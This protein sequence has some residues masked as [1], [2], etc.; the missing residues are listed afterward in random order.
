MGR[1]RTHRFAALPALLA[2]A[3]LA[4]LPVAAAAQVVINEI[5]PDPAGTDDPLERVE[6]YNAG[7]TAVDVTGW[8]IHDAASIDGSPALRCRIPEDF[9][10]AACPGGAIMQPGEFRVVKATTVMAWLNQGGDDVYLCSNRTIPATIVHQVTYPS[11]AGHV[12]EV[13]AAVPNGTSNFAWRTLSLCATNGGGGDVVAPA[14]VAN[15]AAT[16]GSFPGEIRL[17]WTAPGDDGAT[18]TAS[19]YIIKVAHFAIT[20]GTFD[21]VGD[22]DRWTLEPLPAAGGTAETLFVFGLDPDS[23]WFFALETQDEVPN[24]ST[25]SNSP[26]SAPLPGARLNPDL[27]YNAYFGNLHSHTGYSDGVQTPPIAYN[28]ARNI[29][30]TPLDFLAVTDHNHTTAGMSLPDYHTGLSEGASANS[31]GNFVAIYGQ[32]WGLATNGHVNVYE[33]PVLFG[34]DAGNF[35]TF[36]AEGDYAGLYSAAI[37]NPP[38]SYPV[39]IEWAHPA[40]GDFDNFQVTNDGRAAVH[41]MA[42]VNGPATSTAT[43]ESDIGNTGFDGAFHE[44]LRAGYRVSPTAD[45][46]NHNATWGASTE[47][48]TGV[49][50]LSKTKSA[51]LTAMAARR[52][53]ATQD[54]NAVVHFSADGHA[55]GEA[56]TATQG[57][58]I[59][60]EVIDTDPGETVSKIDLFRGITGTSIATRVGGNSGSSKFQWRELAPPAPGTEYHYYVEARMADNQNIWTGPVYVTYQ[61]SPVAIVEPPPDWGLGLTARPN[62]TRAGV[63]AD[64]ILP[65][66][67]SHVSLA[68]YDLSGRLRRTLMSG[69]LYAGPHRVIWDGR[70]ESG[71]RPAA[72]VYFMRL[73]TGTQRIDRKVLL[74]P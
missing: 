55:M 25:I 28:F 3:G 46:D 56:F 47:S 31:D 19:A 48:R 60:V 72:G 37:A 66:D 8:C 16:P 44:A 14:A 73:D 40:I 45:Q 32:E 1:S 18:G 57:V 49:L 15:L 53:Y 65:R 74:L 34:W 12:D 41:L 5:Y 51:I 24:T 50:A 17:T 21:A 70:A 71:E 29:A 62:P 26:G 10:T 20:A 54:H 69:A 27:G 30:P 13:W 7:L 2:L 22:L 11:A 9:D 33:A 58:R 52:T 36:V 63:T 43:D 38:P 6:I 39:V 61:T 68:I 59:A 23:T 42:L 4:L 67:A 35:D 64:F